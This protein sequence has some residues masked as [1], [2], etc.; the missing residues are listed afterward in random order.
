MAWTNPRTWVA[1][2]KPTAATMNLHIRDNLNYI[3]ARIQVGT[4]S[5]TPSAAN[6]PTSVTVTFPIAFSAIPYV[7]ISAAT[8]VPGTTVTGW[9]ADTETT[10]N[11]RATVTRTNTTATVLRWIAILP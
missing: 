9:A 5:I 4:V 11:F 2:E 7:V 6:T 10:T 3:N 8:G 1:A